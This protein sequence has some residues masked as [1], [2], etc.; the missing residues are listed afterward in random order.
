MEKKEE[1]EEEDDAVRTSAFH[2]HRQ[3][4][5]HPLFGSGKSSGGRSSRRNI[6]D[7]FIARC[8]QGAA[9]DHIECRFP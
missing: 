7:L 1:E 8:R 4:P 2:H 6:F 5:D 3:Q 9:A